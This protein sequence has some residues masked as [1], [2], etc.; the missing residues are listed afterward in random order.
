MGFEPCILFGVV[1]V[2]RQAGAAVCLD[3]KLERLTCCLSRRALYCKPG[4][5][6]SA[7]SSGAW[8]G[9]HGGNGRGYVRCKTGGIH[10]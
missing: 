5:E 10:F 9:L 6:G 1:A 7:L 4:V 2:C 3:E 8:C